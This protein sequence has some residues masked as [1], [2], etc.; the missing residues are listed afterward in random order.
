MLGGWSQRDQ[1]CQFGEN[2]MN[3]NN[4][5]SPRSWKR[6]LI[7]LCFGRKTGVVFI[8]FVDIGAIGVARKGILGDG[9]ASAAGADGEGWLTREGYWS[10]SASWPRAT[11]IGG[12]VAHNVNLGRHRPNCVGLCIER[13]DR[14]GRYRLGGEGS[15]CIVSEEGGLGL[16]YESVQV[17]R[18]SAVI[19][20]AEYRSPRSERTDESAES[21]SPVRSRCAMLVRIEVIFF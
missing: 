7:L 5:Y 18:S 10:A 16:W 17:V 14:S 1:R 11:S 19:G 15:Y 3:Q 20:G 13:S 21:A 6:K 9:G 12:R 2:T 8:F 4:T